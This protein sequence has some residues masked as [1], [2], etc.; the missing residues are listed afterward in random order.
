MRTSVIAL[1]PCL[2]CAAPAAAAERVTAIAGAP[3]R[4]PSK[5]DKAFVTKFGPASAKRVLVLMPGYS[6]LD[7]LT[8]AADRNRFLRTVVPFLRTVR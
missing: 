5:C 4:G 1:L 6:F 7:P 8:A 2:A 3:G